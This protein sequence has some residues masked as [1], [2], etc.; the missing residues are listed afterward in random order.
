MTRGAISLGGLRRTCSARLA[1]ALLV[2]LVAA[3][4]LATA[5]P[6][7]RVALVIGNSAYQH[8]RELPNPRNDAEALTVELEELGFDVTTAIDRSLAQTREAILEFGQRSYGADVALIFYAGHGFQLEGENYLLAVDGR[9]DG[10]ADLEGSAVRTAELHEAFAFARPGL[11]VLILD[12]CRDNPFA[13]LVGGRQGLSSGAPSRHALGSARGE[14]GT[15][16]AFSAAPGAVALDGDDGNSPFTTALLQWIGRSDLEIGFMFRKVRRTV[17]TLT[18]NR[19]VPWVEESL[20]EEVYL[21]RST[22]G[23]GGARAT[24]GLA[25]IL[26]AAVEGLEHPAERRAARAFAA[27]LL[28]AGDAEGLAAPPG[29]DPATEDPAFLR[30][31]FAWLSIRDSNEP[32]IFRAFLAEHPSGAFAEL[33]AARLASVSVPPKIQAPPRENAPPEASA[34]PPLELDGAE[35]RALQRLLA[36]AGHDAGAVDGAIGP[37]SRAALAAF[38]SEVGLPAT[39]EADRATLTA[40]VEAAAR[41]ALLDGP[42]APERAALHRLAA[43]AR[44]GPGAEPTTLRVASYARYEEV[45]DHW[46]DVAR[47]F[48]ADHPGVT[49]AFDLRPV[50]AYKAELLTM[51]GAERPPD[52]FVTWGGGHLRSLVEAGFARDL[53][54]AQG[55][56]GVLRYKPGSLR[57][58]VVEGR[59]H[60][61][62]ARMTLVSLWA[63]RAKLERAGVDPASL[64]SWDGLLDAVRRLRAAGITPLAVGT[65]DGWPMQLY[66]AGL[67]QAVG[68][69]EAMEAALAGE[70]EGFAGPAFVEAGARLRELAALDPFQRGHETMGESEALGVFT[71]GHAAMT[72]DGDWIRARLLRSWAGGPERAAEELVRIPFPPLGLGAGA[73]EATLGG[74]DAW[75]VREG[76]PDVAV[77]LLRALEGPE[78]QSDLAGL[79]FGIPTIPGADAAIKDPVLREVA[80]ELTLSE[81]HQLFL[82]QLLGPAAGAAANE[83]AVALASGEVTPERA[84]AAVERAY[85]PV[86]EAW[87]EG[88]SPEPA[89]PRPALPVPAE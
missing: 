63:N 44:G 65:A 49:V 7:A 31:G 55:E 41:P 47:R 25:E 12:A 5:G 48:E 57:N 1:V 85:V 89:G 14:A 28:P 70:A 19:Q 84:A 88:G 67:A 64:R 87:A 3:A 86:R 71:D 61:L 33:A 18:D 8:V 27:R 79:G 11:A 75:V 32:D 36:A 45:L 10:P 24:A 15:L 26:S 22:G 77:E 60:A 58:L 53:T 78:A 37:T 23:A 34:A 39:G 68:G 43:R 30:E 54:E 50:E 81:H 73:F 62:P 59:V 69:R 2:A 76:A 29:A 20:V 52:L 38:Q 17:M 56:D 4:A 35:R 9:L 6:P 82:D 66:W 83:V 42:P 46:R 13:G 16:I 72:L 74:V 80:A 40:L 21:R 51:L